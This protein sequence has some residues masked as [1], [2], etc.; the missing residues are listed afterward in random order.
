MVNYQR[1][2]DIYCLINGLEDTDELINAPLLFQRIREKLTP[3]DEAI[4]RDRVLGMTYKEI[5]DKLGI[6]TSHVRERL[7]KNLRKMRHPSF[8]KDIALND[9]LAKY[10]TS[11]AQCKALSVEID[12]LKEITSKFSIFT[13]VELGTII[14]LDELNLS[15]R[16]YNCLRRRDID[17]V[18]ALVGLS[19]E[20]LLQTDNLGLVSAKDIS[21][22][23]RRLGFEGWD[24]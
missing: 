2:H 18:N 14:P 10:Q 12:K 3:D 9:I 21:A 8:L 16:S 4:L 15:C 19:K 11:V 13:K 6:S 24:F 1:A 17:T 20:E 22:A 5:G 7:V 23:V